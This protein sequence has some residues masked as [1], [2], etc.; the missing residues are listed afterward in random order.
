VRDSLETDDNP[1][2]GV[3]RWFD[4]AAAMGTEKKERKRVEVERRIA[5]ANTLAVVSWV[6]RVCDSGGF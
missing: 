5:E 1:A 6:Q 4:A 2:T 3:V